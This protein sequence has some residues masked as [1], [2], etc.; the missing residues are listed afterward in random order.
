MLIAC[1]NESNTR[2]MTKTHMRKQ[3]MKGRMLKKA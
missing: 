3:L 1:S 2:W